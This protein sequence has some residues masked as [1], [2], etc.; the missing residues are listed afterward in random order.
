MTTRKII[1]V[2]SQDEI[3]EELPPENIEL[4]V[5]QPSA[6]IGPRL[7]AAATEIYPVEAFND[8]QVLAGAR[9]FTE[10]HTI[11]ALFSFTEYGLLPAANA[12]KTLGLP[13]ID[14]DV[15]ELCRNKW[16]LREKLAATRLHVPFV[17]A[18]NHDAIMQFAAINGF[19]LVLKDPS[20]VGSINVKICTTLIEALD[21]FD[22][23]TLQHYAYV[24]VE[25]FVAGTEY[26][27]ETLSIRGQ[28]QLIG[29][30]DKR[31]SPGGLV[32]QSHI[33][34]AALTQ[35]EIAQIEPYIFTLLERIQHRHGPM[36]IEV[37]LDGEQIHLIEIN[38]R[39]GG[40]YIWDMVNKVSGVNLVAETLCY[41][42]EGQPDPLVRKARQ[43]YGAM[44]YIAL[45]QP[46]LPSAIRLALAN[47]TGLD[48]V[49]CKTPA[50]PTARK[51]SNSFERPGFILIGERDP[52]ALNAVLP[53]IEQWIDAQ[54][55]QHGSV[56]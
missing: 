1:M 36:H 19:P 4:Y 51:V 16:K 28:H 46:L 10:R 55:H 27:V 26:S 44:S 3:F 8:E 23:L 35:A 39:P 24:L 49:Q 11:D 14:V 20:G 2:G 45:F 22:E 53:T 17:M 6:L 50:Q 13:G 5:I 37:K 54:H 41:A 34:P 21:F 32:E 7:Q 15:T 31:L 29:I 43:R 30:T 12:A 48:R 9:Y 56:V 42:F 52:T 38:N 47:R 25:K 18:A 33:Y 40:D